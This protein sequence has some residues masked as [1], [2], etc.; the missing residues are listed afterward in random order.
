M[1]LRFST[2]MT[3][4][5]TTYRHI[6]F[7]RA[8]PAPRAKRFKESWTCI[9]RQRMTCRLVHL[10]QVLTH[11]ARAATK[12]FSG[13]R[14]STCGVLTDDIRLPVLAKRLERSVSFEPRA[15]RVS[16]RQAFSCS[17]FSIILFTLTRAVHARGAAGPRPPE[18]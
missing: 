9:A 18:V 13:C 8:A 12:C 5:F 10:Y 3:C 1:T 16:P 2:R 15:G 6:C 14:A 17:R 4:R 11:A 7:A